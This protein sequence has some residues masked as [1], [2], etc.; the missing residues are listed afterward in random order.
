MIGVVLGN[1]PLN[2]GA[3]SA[4]ELAAA[5]HEVRVALADLPARLAIAGGG[6]AALR[7]MAVE[8]ALEGADLVIVDIPP[9][10]LLRV[11]PPHLGALARVPAVQV[12]SHGYWPALRLRD[13]AAV[14]QEL[15]DFDR[16]WGPRLATSARG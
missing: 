16:D 6:S 2:I 8:S 12:N 13:G 9:R 14:R 4:V 5:G 7:P 10:D 11:L 3:A 15:L 1:S